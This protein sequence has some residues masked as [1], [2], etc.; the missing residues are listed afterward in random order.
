MNSFGEESIENGQHS[1]QTTGLHMIITRMKIGTTTCCEE[2]VDLVI[3]AITFFWLVVVG[4]GG[5]LDWNCGEI[6]WS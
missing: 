6:D 4:D 3:V 1:S 5:G 2:Y